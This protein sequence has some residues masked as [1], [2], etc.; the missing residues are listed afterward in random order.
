MH[1][2][3]SRDRTCMERMRPRMYHVVYA[4]YA[5]AVNI[6]VT[7]RPSTCSGIRFVINTY[8]PVRQDPRKEIKVGGRKRC[9]QGKGGREEERAGNAG[10]QQGQQRRRT[11]TKQANKHLQPLP[12]P[13]VGHNQQQL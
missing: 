11:A 3:D 1:S 13:L 4:V 6:P 5:R 12:I 8:P 7:I 9:G 2:R 10:P